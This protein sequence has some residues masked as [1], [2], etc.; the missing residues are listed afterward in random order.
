MASSGRDGCLVVDFCELI[1]NSVGF[2]LFMNG[3]HCPILDQSVWSHPCNFS[4]VLLS[5]IIVS[6][7]LHSLPVHHRPLIRL[8]TATPCLLAASSHATGCEAAGESD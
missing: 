5:F 4:V 2:I 3:N 8:L 7:S 6:Y 1:L